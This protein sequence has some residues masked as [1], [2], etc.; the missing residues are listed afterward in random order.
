MLRSPSGFLVGLTFPVLL[1]SLGCGSTDPGEFVTTHVAEVTG[2]VLN[3][4]RA[5]QE[6]VSVT[7][8]PLRVD[9]AYEA[10]VGISDRRGAFAFQLG[11]I[12]GSDRQDPDTLSVMVILRAIGGRYPRGPGGAELVDSLPVVV[13]FAKAGAPSAVTTVEAIFRG[14]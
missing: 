13:R 5:P 14:L 11:R 12:D 3:A 10:G 1:G 7:A 6:S 8:R 4:T 2:S 9:A